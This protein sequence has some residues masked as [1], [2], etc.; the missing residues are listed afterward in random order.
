[1]KR[2][3]STA[4]A[5][6]LVGAATPTWAD[7]SATLRVK[8]FGDVKYGGG[9][10]RNSALSKASAHGFGKKDVRAAA[11]PVKLCFAP[12]NGNFIKGTLAG[13][14]QRSRTTCTST[15]INRLQ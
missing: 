10:A 9:T 15:S 14:T 4:V 3:I 8:V 11:T 6:A 12:S 7:P 5:L 13:R 1:M 2:L